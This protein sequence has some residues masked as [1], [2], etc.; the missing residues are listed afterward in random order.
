MHL[1]ILRIRIDEFKLAVC[2]F[3]QGKPLVLAQGGPS[4]IVG[5][6]PREAYTMLLA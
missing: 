2:S 4:P 5:P 3:W 6:W 1:D